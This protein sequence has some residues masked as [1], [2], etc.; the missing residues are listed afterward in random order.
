LSY[1]L[2]PVEI[3]NVLRYT[4]AK[5][6]IFDEAFKQPRARLNLEIDKYVIGKGENGFIR[7][8]GLLKYDPVESAVEIRDDN[9]GYAGFTSGTKGVPKVLPKNTIT[10]NFLN[11]V[12]YTISFDMTLSGHIA[13][14]V[15]P[16]YRPRLGC[17]D[18]AGPG[19]GDQ[20]RFR[21]CAI[22]QA[23][24]KYRV[25]YHVRCARHVLPS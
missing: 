1:R 21:S 11:H 19:N 6:L 5:T 14:A 20:Y 8:D 2:S 17:G 23:I 12:C 3:E 9:A 25:N 4:G 10:A 24:E 7:Y 16:L 15:P 18:H 13:H 22:L